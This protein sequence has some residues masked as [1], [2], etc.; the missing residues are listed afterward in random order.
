MFPTADATIVAVGAAGSTVREKGDYRWL[1]SVD[2][3]IQTVVD[4]RDPSRVALPVNQAMLAAFALSA[5]ADCVLN[6]GTGGGAFERLVQRK[7]PRT[8][9][10]SVEQSPGMVALAKAHFF[11]PKDFP[12]HVCSAEDYLGDCAVRFDVVLA[13]LFHGNALPDCLYTMEFYA[14]LAQLLRPD[15]VVAVNLPHLGDEHLI[16]VLLPLR[17]SLPWVALHKVAGFDNLIAFAA[18]KTPEQM[19]NPAVTHVTEAIAPSLETDTEQLRAG[20]DV[21]PMPV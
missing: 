8:R 15:G 21:L 14:G 7:L 10:I 6:L 19:R 20:L 3:A 17:K 13:D 5:S 16:R 4:L 2:G 18:L 12:V 1:E 11:L 9:L